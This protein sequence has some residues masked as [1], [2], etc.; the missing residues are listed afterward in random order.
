[1]SDLK[2]YFESNDDR[3]IH[4]WDHY[5]DIYEQFFNKYRNKD[6]VILEIWVSQWGS[7]QMWKDYFWERAKIYWIDIDPNC[8]KYE[9]ENIEIF[10][11]S[12]SDRSFLRSVKNKIP[13]VDI[14]ID[15]WWHTMNQQIVSFEELF[16]HIKSDW[17]YLCEDNHTSYRAHFWWWYK[18]KWTYIEYTKKL[19]DKLHARHSQQSRLKVDSFTKSVRGIYYFDSIVVIEKKPVS[20]PFHIMTWK[21]WHSQSYAK[22][23][24][25][26]KAKAIINSTLMHL[27]L[28][29]MH[30]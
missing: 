13:K 29:S 27:W 12:Q 14:L 2:K 25:L 3:L 18:R 26:V 1:M 4:K 8:K 11:W 9:E 16:D 28:P 6:V 24:F 10:I 22:E 5:F 30:L 15:D 20:K 19:I 7:L 21:E 23:W 17:I